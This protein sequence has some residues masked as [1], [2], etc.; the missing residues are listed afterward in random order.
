MRKNL[1]LA[2]VLTLSVYTGWAQTSYETA[3]EA[4]EGN[5][6]YTVEGSAPDSIFWKYIPTEDC[7][8]Y[9]NSSVGSMG[10]Y[11][12]SGTDTIQLKGARAYPTVIYPFQ[13]DE[14]VYFMAYGTGEMSF[15]LDKKLVPGLGSGLTKDNA[16][17]IE[18]DTVQFIGNAKAGVNNYDNYDMYA[19]YTADKDGVL[20]VVTKTYLS[21]V[22]ADGAPVDVSYDA[23]YNNV[24][25]I[26]VT[27]G[28][29]TEIVFNT[30]NP[31]MFSA[32]MTYPTAGSLDKP[33]TLAEGDNTVP[34]EFGTYY[35][36]YVPSKAGVMTI[37]SSDNLVGGRVAVYASKDNITYKF[38]ASQSPIGTFNVRTEV[39]NMYV[40]N[41]YYI[42][43][44]KVEDTDAPQTF[45]LAFE[46]YKQGETEDNP[47][48]LAEIPTEQT[49]PSAQGTYYYAVNVPAGTEKYLAVKAK[50]HLTNKENTRVAIY[51]QGF[52]YNPASDSVYARYNVSGTDDQTYIIRWIAQ[53]EAPVTFNVNYEDIQ[54]GEVITKPLAAKAGNNTISGNGTWYYTYTATRTG[55]L[56]IT[57]PEDNTD[58]DITFPKGTGTYDGEYD[59]VK[60]GFTFSIAATKGTTYLIKLMDAKAD[61][62]FTLEETDFA[63][64]ESRENPIEV[65]DKYDIDGKTAGNTWLVYDVKKAGMLEIKC[66]ATYDYSSDVSAGKSTEDYLPTLMTSVE[67]GGDYI[68]KY[69]GTIKVAEGDKI[70]VHLQLK[71]S[72]DLDGK[73]VTFNL[74]DFEPG[75]DFS[76]PLEL[77]DGLTATLPAASYA[78]P[79]WCK[80]NLTKPSKWFFD[81]SG[82]IQG[83]LYKGKEDAAADVNSEML[84]LNVEYGDDWSATYSMSDSIKAGEEGEYYFKFT[85]SYEPVTVKVTITEDPTLGINTVNGNAAAFRMVGNTLV[86]NGDADVKVYSLNGVKVAERNA[87]GTLLLNKGIYIVNVN[88]KAQKI[89]VK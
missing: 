9:V 71:N 79:V 81:L 73:T 15:T 11:T 75:E 86:V 31:F 89:A 12:I 59:V 78:V 53:E 50:N 38:P 17:K 16:L 33:F 56:S 24:Y 51:P 76:N 55:K 63:Q 74:R 37:S 77:T 66:D 80:M 32:R 85:M 65:T 18:L 88:G 41:T 67:E 36:T 64:G 40:G 68:S 35:Y 29:A 20:E 5:N 57:G 28:K 22:T 47:L 87:Q 69:E 27:A 60:S 82:S 6:A 19:T 42:E 54:A 72:L 21:K 14:P 58:L 7:I 3:L 62:V 61:D 52:S 84:N 49:L 10:V 2:S 8:G 46:E 83:Y 43:V 1:L 23:Q 70:L 45:Q 48:V 44:S 30:S 4:K 25:K 13:K 26:P 34:A 39:T